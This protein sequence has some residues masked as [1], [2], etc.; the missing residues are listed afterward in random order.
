MSKISITG[1]FQY[2]SIKHIIYQRK[3]NEGTIQYNYSEF[4]ER[5]YAYHDDS[6]YETIT[7]V[8][9]L[10]RSKQSIWLTYRWDSH[11]AVTVTQF[12]RL[13]DIQDESNWL[14]QKIYRL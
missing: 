7:F 10:T 11:L 3:H 12:T 9:K 13:T 2:H 5:K 1:P 14:I 6:V 4:T 8:T